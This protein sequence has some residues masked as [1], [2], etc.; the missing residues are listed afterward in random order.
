MLS[1]S[2]M[3]SSLNDSTQQWRWPNALLLQGRSVCLLIKYAS[4]PKPSRPEFPPCYEFKVSALVIV[5]ML[6]WWGGKR[7]YT[8]EFHVTGDKMWLL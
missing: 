1:R 7:C 5:H 8:V 2:K 6:K 3:F 4:P